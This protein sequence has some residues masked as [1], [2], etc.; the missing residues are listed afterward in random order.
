MTPREVL[1]LPMDG[2]DAGAKTVGGYLQALLRE[3]W[4]EEESFDG[5]RPFGNSAW[6]HDLYRPLITAGAVEGGSLDE[7][8]Y[9]EELGNADR[10]VFD[11]ID[12]LFPEPWGVR[13]A[14]RIAAIALRAEADTFDPPEG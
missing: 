4:R 9:V 3:V 12:A 5:K 8:G 1:M 6:Q 2:N 14:A 11:A 10:V 7:N 13:D